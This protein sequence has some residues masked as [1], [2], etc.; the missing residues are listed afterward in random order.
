MQAIGRDKDQTI[1][2]LKQSADEKELK[3]LVVSL[4]TTN[5][6]KDEKIRELK[7]QRDEYNQLFGG[8]GHGGCIVTIEKLRKTLKQ[9][10]KGVETI[11]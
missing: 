3:A 11:K 2:F 7:V 1:N 6:E 9:S 8:Y 10:A 5:R 4:E